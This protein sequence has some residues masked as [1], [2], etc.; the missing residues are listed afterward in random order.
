MHYTT[1]A[2]TLV[3]LGVLISI[4]F[5]VHTVS[6]KFVALLNGGLPI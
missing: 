3:G 6:Q 4:L 5:Y 1:P 2:L